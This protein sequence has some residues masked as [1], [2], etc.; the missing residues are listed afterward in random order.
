MP[1]DDALVGREF[2]PT[3]PYPVTEE[4]V[5]AFAAAVGVPAT[6]VP[7]TFPIV[8]VLPALLRLLEDEQVE[9]ARIIHGDQKFAYQRPV[10]VGD[11]LTATISID[12]VRHARGNDIVRTSARVT[13]AAGDVVC[14][15]SS[16][17]VH[18]GVVA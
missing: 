7:P 15:T 16:T 6:T 10:A 1:I 11:R 8:V 13:D 2:P 12:T 3:E 4:A 5:S 17:L 18:L 9:L 14:T